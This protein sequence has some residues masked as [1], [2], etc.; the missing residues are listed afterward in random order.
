MSIENLFLLQERRGLVFCQED[1]AIL[2]RDCD[3]S[4]HS[5]NQL[6]M[7]HGRFLLTGARLSATPLASASHL[8]EVTELDS[9]GVINNKPAVYPTI[10][11]VPSNGGSSS[12][13]SSISDYL[14]KT[15]PGYR[16]EDL[17]DDDGSGLYKVCRFFTFASLFVHFCARLL[18]IL[19]L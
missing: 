9:N 18:L 7:K 2:C 14:T 8:K 6:T 15:L 13:S 10:S 3:D 1:R 19:V 5:A 17:L 11:L 4:I 12:G 16:V